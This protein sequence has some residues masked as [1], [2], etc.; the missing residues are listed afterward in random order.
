MKTK[1]RLKTGGIFF[2]SNNNSLPLQSQTKIV[3]VAGQS[4]CNN[5]LLIRPLTLPLVIFKENKIKIFNSNKN[6][7]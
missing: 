5:C 1:Y 3:N 4:E 2:D 7:K 6:K